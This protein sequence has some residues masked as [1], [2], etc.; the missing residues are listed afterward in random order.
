MKL[1]SEVV[2]RLKADIDSG[3]WKSGEKI[4]AEPELMKRYGVGRS[5][6]REAIKTLAMSGLLKVQQGSGTFVNNHFEDMTIEQRLRRAD[7]DDINAVRF[8]LEKEIVNLATQQHT[9]AQLAEIAANLER[10]KQAIQAENAEACAEADISFHMAI[11]RA[12]GNPVLAD[13][14][15]HFTLIMRNFFAARESHGISRFAMNHF[16][17]EQLYQAIKGRKARQS[18]LVLQKILDNNY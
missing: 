17:H 14:Y 10:R 8:L 12:S 7:F 1:Y 4:P 11:A 6:V 5:T 2:D 3:T 18:Q 15:F 13:L 16:L 9:E